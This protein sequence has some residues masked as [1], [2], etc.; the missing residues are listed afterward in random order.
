MCSIG[1]SVLIGRDAVHD[2]PVKDYPQVG[3]STHPERPLVRD[4]GHDAAVYI[5]KE[6]I[7]GGE[8][9]HI[10]HDTA[11]YTHIYIYIYIYVYIYIYIYIYEKQ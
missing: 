7:T 11:V 1:R 10:V 5:S 8:S 2:T 3:P 6:I 4:R 9:V